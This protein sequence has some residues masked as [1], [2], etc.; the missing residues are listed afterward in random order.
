[1]VCGALPEAAF[2]VQFAARGGGV[3]ALGV[4]LGARVV[5]GQPAVDAQLRYA[6]RRAAV[7]TPVHLARESAGSAR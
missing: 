3:L 2:S 6:G 4:K 1:M 5:E 7:Q